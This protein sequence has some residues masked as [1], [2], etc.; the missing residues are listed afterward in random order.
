MIKMDHLIICIIQMEKSIIDSIDMDA[1]MSSNE[2]VIDTIKFCLKTNPNIRYRVYNTKYVFIV[3][4][5]TIILV[6]DYANDHW[7]L[8]ISNDHQVKL[9]GGY[10]YLDNHFCEHL[11]ST[12]TLKFFASYYDYDLFKRICYFLLID[13][14]YE[15][16]ERNNY[17]FHSCSDELIQ[18]ILQLH[19]KDI[20]HK[21]SR[22]LVLF[23]LQLNKEKSGFIITFH[24]DYGLPQY[25]IKPGR[26]LFDLSYAKHQSKINRNMLEWPIRGNSFSLKKFVTVRIQ[27]ILSQAQIANI[28]LLL[29]RELVP[30]IAI[31]IGKLYFELCYNSW[32]L[33]FKSAP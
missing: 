29:K 10:K 7:D 17:P 24:S 33:S 27:A 30:D 25:D 11:L 3:T 2:P 14:N 1:Y 12:W 5:T 26:M 4:N 32:D 6:E 31:S 8:K 22:N 21:L 18:S 13:D 9:I 19:A 16:L 15:N 20:S 23:D 28:N